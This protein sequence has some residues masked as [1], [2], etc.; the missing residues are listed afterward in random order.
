MEANILD[1]GQGS[2]ADPETREKF[3][4]NIEVYKPKT[5]SNVTDKYVIKVY[6]KLFSVSQNGFLVKKIVEPMLQKRRLERYFN[7]ID[8]DDL[9][10]SA[11]AGF[12]KHFRYPH[13]VEEL[14][15]DLESEN[16][17]D[18]LVH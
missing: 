16:L 15:F 1:E 10:Q 9:P 11:L 13:L 3:L 7:E 2:L 5:S 8:V 4:N 12:L 18:F 17:F 14:E 6:G